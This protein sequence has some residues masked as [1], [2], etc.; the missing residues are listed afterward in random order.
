M[1][2]LD[3]NDDLKDR[4]A[5]I[6]MPQMRYMT[7]PLPGSKVPAHVQLLLPSGYRDYEDQKFPLLMHL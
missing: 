4:L 3:Q 5:E 6:K 1:G 2:W 7:V